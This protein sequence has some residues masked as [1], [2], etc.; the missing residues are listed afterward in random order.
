MLLVLDQGPK[1][2]GPRVAAL[3]TGMGLSAIVAFFRDGP[4]KLL[5]GQISLGANGAAR[6]CAW[7]AR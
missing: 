1:E 5:P 7:A 2:A 4:W 3:G 6:R